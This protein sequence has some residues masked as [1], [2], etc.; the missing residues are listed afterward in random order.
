MPGP[1]TAWPYAEW[2]RACAAA[3]ARCRDDDTGAC[4]PPLRAS[5]SARSGGAVAEGRQ[6]G[7]SV[8]PAPT[9]L[10]PVTDISAAAWVVEGVGEFASGVRG[11]LPPRFDAY[12][13]ILH[14]AWPAGDAI[15]DDAA[16][17]P[18]TWGE[19]AAATGRQVHARVQFDALV[20]VERGNPR[21]YEPDVGEIPPTLLSALCDLLG[22]HTATPE[23]CWFCL[24]DGWG[25]IG[26]SPSAGVVVAED[27]RES[28]DRAE[29][30][31]EVPPAFGPE[32]LD[33]PRVSIPGRDYILFEGPL[34]AAGELGWRTGAL[35]SAAYPERDFDP[36]EFEPQS[37][38]IFWP[39]DRAWCVATEI[40]L[41]STYVGGSRQLIEALLDDTRFEAWR[42]E[43]DDPIDSR[44][45]DVNE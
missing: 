19:V 40:D 32:I 15:A 20:G 23:R 30:V 42:A 36:D 34:A 16:L 44:G 12:A 27:A 33:G 10:R 38:S 29:S 18:V 1:A 13:R 28:A 21:P 39:E 11:L 3:H 2:M 45:D 24:W 17:R 43:L 41:D 6:Y 22:R 8:S 31:I 9:R 5:R 35:L 7:R 14:P 4:D 26:G 25:W 37:P